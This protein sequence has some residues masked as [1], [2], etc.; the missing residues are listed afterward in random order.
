[1]H[2][3]A[4]ESEGAGLQ[5]RKPASIALTKVRL[6]D[7]A[8]PSLQAI[9]GSRGDHVVEVLRVH[10]S[11][12][13]AS[14]H[15]RRADGG[16]AIL[17]CLLPG[18]AASSAAGLKRERDFYAARTFSLAA[19]L[20]ESGADFYIRGYENG[21]PLRHC[22]IE[23]APETI[24]RLPSVLSALVSALAYSESRTHT[25]DIAAQAAARATSRFSNLM[26]SG[27]AGTAPRPPIIE[28]AAR[29][30]A[31]AAMRWLGPTVA[32]MTTRWEQAHVR[33]VSGFTHNDL[34][35]DNVLLTEAGPR[36]VDFENVTT[37]GFFW[38]DAAYLTATCFAALHNA[39]ARVCLIDD[40]ATAI[41]AVDPRLTAGV[42]SLT[43]VYCG[44]AASNARF[45]SGRSSD[46]TD[47]RQWLRAARALVHLAGS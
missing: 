21:R 36:V 14:A 15:I 33:F 26:N 24:A 8:M 10:P 17:K 46:A 12:R 6:D 45:R 44:A 47:A 7:D 37:P 38:I 30:F 5:L 40:L 20:L 39:P 3:R 18:A 2:E 11:K 13:T 27:P 41:D 22:L 42:R 35:G 23:G 31:Y 4:V 1:M 29:T 43:E 34:H 9:C 19:P 16:E 25:P 28:R 32:A